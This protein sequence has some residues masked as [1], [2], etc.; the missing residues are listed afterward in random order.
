MLVQHPAHIAE[1]P[2][3]A[4]QPV[5]RVEFVRSQ[6]AQLAVFERQR[7]VMAAYG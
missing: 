5:D 2:P 3:V 6:P 7:L 1:Q 4:V